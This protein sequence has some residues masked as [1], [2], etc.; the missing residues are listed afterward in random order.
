MI[1]WKK[2]LKELKVPKKD[3]T[4]AML[5]TEETVAG[6][7]TNCTDIS[8]ISISL[9]KRGRNSSIIIRAK[10]SEFHFE[11]SFP[12]FDENLG[13]DTITISSG[14][15]EQSNLKKCGIAIVLAIVCGLLFRY[16]AP[17][18]VN[19]FLSTKILGTITTVFMNA[20]KMV[21]GPLIF[22]SLA[23][24]IGSFTDMKLL[25]RIGG[26]VMGFYLFNYLYCNNNRNCSVQLFF[27]CQIRRFASFDNADEKYIPKYMFK[28]NKHGIY[29]NGVKIVAIIVST[30]II[31]PASCQTVLEFIRFRETA[32]NAE[33]PYNS[34]TDQLKKYTL[35]ENFNSDTDKDY[36]AEDISLPG[37]SGSDFFADY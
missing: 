4:R 21:T 1:S 24:C 29:S 30:L 9:K 7:I 25:G 34:I 17:E 6:M 22:F 3:I 2:N 13:L 36:T 12:E 10:G 35:N 19:K 20:L 31:L 23:A 11:N 15:A 32:E 28:K 18:D 27:F 26:K 16:L 8:D 37:Q 5:L 33:I 14:K